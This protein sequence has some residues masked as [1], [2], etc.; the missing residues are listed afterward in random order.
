MLDIQLET[1]HLTTGLELAHLTIS[2]GDDQAQMA[3]YPGLSPRPNQSELHAFQKLAPFY[4][5]SSKSVYTEEFLAALNKLVPAHWRFPFEILALQMDHPHLTPLKL[6]S[7]ELI[8]DQAHTP[9]EQVNPRAPC[10]KIKIGRRPLAQEIDYLE[11]IVQH[12]NARLRLDANELLTYEQ[13][14][15]LEH[16]FLAPHRDRLDYLESPCSS[17]DWQRFAQI[18]HYPLAHDLRPGDQLEHILQL[19][20]LD[21]VI[22]KPTLLSVQKT[23][24]VDHE[25]P[26]SIEL[27][28]SSCFEGEIGLRNLSYLAHWSKRLKT[29]TPQ[30]LGTLPWLSK[31]Q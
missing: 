20:Q 16:E 22:I 13:L 30:G 3:L 29:G 27:I 23:L 1:V 7:A 9:V 21:T 8:F 4:E 19:A 11:N 24:E 25:L 5:R 12:T 26:E 17:K 15:Q 31:A 2:R 6:Q 14:V 18:Y 10:L 28:F